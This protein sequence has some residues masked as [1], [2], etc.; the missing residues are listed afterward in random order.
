MRYIPG[1]DV[2][3]GLP[4]AR[5]EATPGRPGGGCGLKVFALSTFAGPITPGL[6]PMASSFDALGLCGARWMSSC[7]AR[8][9]PHQA[10]NLSHV[11]HNCS[12]HAQILFRGATMIPHGAR[13]LSHA[14]QNRCLHA[15]IPFHGA[16][17]VPHGAR[18]LS[19]AAQ[20]RSFHAQIPFHGA[21]MVLYGARDHPPLVHRSFS[22]SSDSSRG[23]ESSAVPEPLPHSHFAPLSRLSWA[24]G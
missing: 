5:S 17:M 18:N 11:A 8:I 20:N 16:K 19:H 12:H 24:N 21:K 23:C 22:P 3:N 1:S 10:Q 14:A 6:R 7:G 9:P 4:D 13:N 2:R 15:Q